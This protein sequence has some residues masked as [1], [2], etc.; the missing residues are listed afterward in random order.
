MH[1]RLHRATPT[2]QHPE[3]LDLHIEISPGDL[4]ASILDGL[5]PK[6]PFPPSFLSGLSPPKRPIPEEVLDLANIRVRFA[7]IDEIEVEWRRDWTR[8]TVKGRGATMDEAAHEASSGEAEETKR[9]MDPALARMYDDTPPQFAAW[10]RAAD[11]DKDGLVNGNEAVEFFNK[12]GLPTPVLA[13]IWVLADQNRSGTLKQ[14]DFNRAMWL[15]SVAQAGYDPTPAALEKHKHELPLPQLEGVESLETT[16]QSHANS[17]AD[18]EKHDAHPKKSPQVTLGKK[19]KKSAVLKPRMSVKNCSSISEGLKHIYNSKLKAIEA[20]YLFSDFHSPL[21]RDSDFDAK[22][23]VMLLGQYSVG[24]T[25]FIKFL[26]DGEEYPNALIGPEPT[27]DRFVSVMHSH[28]RSSVPGNTLAVQRDQPFSGLAKFGTAFLNKFFGAYMPAELLESITIIDTPGVLSGEKQRLERMYDFP[29]VVKWFAERCDLILVLFDPHKLDISDEFKRVIGALQGNDDK[30]RI[31]LN[32]ADQVSTQHL[33]RVYGALMW[34]L[35]RVVRS[36]EVPRVYIG[37]FREGPYE[38]EENA[39]LLD[40]ERDQLI[41]DLKDIPRRNVARKVN[42]FVKRVRTAKIHML[43][44][45]ALRDRMPSMF[46]KEKKQKK[47]VETLEDV[48]F[49]VQ[50]KHNLPVGDFPPLEPFRE[51]L[52]AHKIEKFPVMNKAALKTLDD[53]LENDLPTLLERFGN[54]FDA[55]G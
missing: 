2:S 10:F 34:S 33:M 54:P 11:R 53:V 31:V 37:N 21:L 1:V 51:C 47:L 6:H 9:T 17:E 45:S 50:R 43:I 32:K 20:T 30:V 38:S 42:E 24:K 13:K 41:V 25:S 36:P 55:E 14:K 29:N 18:G 48:F 49:E 12:S 52:K 4:D 27:T 23:T 39:R 28:D 15:I 22:P 19:K 3:D 26:L 44:I 35:S 46:G 16:H 7:P 8:P 5:R 40:L